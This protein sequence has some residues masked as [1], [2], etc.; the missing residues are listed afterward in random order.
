MSHPRRGSR[1]PH[2]V[3]GGSL[4]M[5]SDLGWGCRRDGGT[6]GVALGNPPALFHV[7]VQLGACRVHL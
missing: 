5:G 6:R 2:E 4:R 1:Y 7:D 3:V